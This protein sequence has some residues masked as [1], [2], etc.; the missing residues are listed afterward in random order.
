MKAPNPSPPSADLAESRSDRPPSWMRPAIVLG[1]AALTGFVMLCAAL[2]DVTR[3]VRAFQVGYAILVVVLLRPGGPAILGRWTPWLFVCVIL[4]LAL[5]HVSPSDD[6]YRYLWEGRIQGHGFNPF[7]LAP[8]APQLQHLRDEDWARINH[9]DYPTIYPPLAQAVFLLTALLCPSIYALKAAN[10]LCDV[11]AVV[12]L[13]RWST[14]RGH[15]PHRALIYGLCPLTLTAFGIDG[16]V[17]GLMLLCLVAAGLL[18]DRGRVYWAA[19]LLAGAIAAKIVAVV[20]VGWLAVRS[21]KA[22]LL[23]LACTAATY[24]PYAAA[25]TGLTESLI[26]FVGTTE[27]FGLLHSLLAPRVGGDASRVIGII[28]LLAVAAWSLLRR[29][30]YA[31]YGR[32]VLAAV[33]LVAP[34]VHFWYV[35]WVLIFLALRPRWCWIILA[36]SMVFY[37]EAERMR[38]LTGQW[39]M[40]S[41]AWYATYLPFVAAWIAEMVIAPTWA[42]WNMPAQDRRT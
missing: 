23:C 39:L 35:T 26:R 37:F 9:P 30:T 8:D 14:A 42:G 40:P 36:G 2:G 21:W 34:V 32:R 22:A 12:L 29:D 10:V 17:D 1:V 25:G 19:V 27:F 18:S 33:I 20:L 24:L 41:W 11:I 3:H 5:L 38:A 13:A 15:P 7:A 6:T 16:H 4:R 31:D 28:L